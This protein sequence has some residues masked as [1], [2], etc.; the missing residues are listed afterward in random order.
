VPSRTTRLI[1]I[2]YRVEPFLDAPPTAS[3]TVEW[4][5]NGRKLSQIEFRASA[6]TSHT[7][8]DAS[9]A[10]A[11]GSHAGRDSCDSCECLE[12]GSGPSSPPHTHILC[13]HSPHHLHHILA[14]PSYIYRYIHTYIHTYNFS[15]PCTS[16]PPPHTHICTY[17][18]STTPRCLH[19]RASTNFLIITRNSVFMA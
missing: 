13:L 5:V 18:Y 8:A 12:M 14:S 6:E 17:I 3:V 2:D 11:L 9:H 16:C 4:R 19:Q 7:L 1:H 15:P 10:L